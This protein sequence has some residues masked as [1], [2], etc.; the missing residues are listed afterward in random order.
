MESGTG[1][2][3]IMSPTPESKLTVQDIN[4]INAALEQAADGRDWLIRKRI[5]DL[6]WKLTFLGQAIEKTT[7]PGA[8]TR[9][10][11]REDALRALLEDKI[12]E[13]RER[14]QTGKGAMGLEITTGGRLMYH[15]CADELAALVSGEPQEPLRREDALR[16]RLQHFVE[17]ERALIESKGKGGQTVGYSPRIT[18]SVLKELERIL[19]DTAALV[20]GEA[21]QD[22]E[23]FTDALVQAHG[24]GQQHTI[25]DVNAGLIDDLIQPRLNAAKVEAEEAFKRDDAMLSVALFEWA[26]LIRL[27]EDQQTLLAVADDIEVNARAMRGPEGDA[28]AALAILSREVSGEAPP[29]HDEEMTPHPFQSRTPYEPGDDR[30]IWC[31]DCEYHRD[32]Q[33]H[34]AAPGAAGGEQA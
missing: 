8:E 6:M 16:A 13:W 15:S 18:P 30:D 34:V 17:R 11:R 20:S 1:G 27:A 25:A 23:K 9:S 21:P 31:K 26:R 10:G 32:H 3:L 29:D 4:E 14:A 33:I 24:E 5:A 2:A 7:P 28:Q 12:A 22:T 19:R